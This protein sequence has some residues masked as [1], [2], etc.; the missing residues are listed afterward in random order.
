MDSLL[1]YDRRDNANK[2]T[3]KYYFSDPEWFDTN[4]QIGDSLIRSRNK[5]KKVIQPKRCMEC[6]RIHQKPIRYSDDKVIYLNSSLFH[7]LK[8]VKETCYECK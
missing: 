8:L 6:K 2:L 3:M 4:I 1:E 5:T 7:N